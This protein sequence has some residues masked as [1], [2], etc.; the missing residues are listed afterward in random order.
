MF[1]L[2]GS[3]I[4]LA[5]YLFK[6]FS[7]MAAFF[8]A[9]GQW[10]R[11]TSFRARRL[12]VTFG[13]L[14]VVQFLLLFM[15]AVTTPE[16]LLN[17]PFERALTVASLGFLLWGFTP[18]LRER[19]SMGLMF[20]I[21]NTVLAFIAYGV[22]MVVWNGSDFNQT[23]WEIFF[24]VWQSLLLL[25]GIIDCSNRYNDERLFVLISF[26]IMLLGYAAHLMLNTQPHIPVFVR[27]FEMIAYPLLT[28]AIYQ[29][30]MQSLV[31]RG[32]EL[33]DLSEISLDQIT[34]LISLSKA[35]R[36]ITA[37]LELSEVL[38][39]ATQSIATALNAD[40]CALALPDEETDLSQL[41]LVSI[42][43]PSRQGRGEAV[44]FPLNDQTA[45]KHAAKNK[46]SIQIDEYQDD[47]PLQLLFTLM[48]AQDA[49]PL[50]IQPLLKND[51]TIGVLLLGNSISKRV[52][53]NAEVE[54][55]HALAEQVTTA[56]S[57]AK[58]YS[59]VSGKSQ[60]LS[61]TLRN[62]ELEAG[63]RRAA[64]ET[65]LKK[66]REEV[67]L[68]AQRLYDYE[69]AQKEKEDALQKSQ[70]NVAKLE[71]MLDRAKTEVEKVGRK[72][73]QVSALSQNIENYKEQIT[74]LEMEQA[75]LQTEIKKL[76]QDTSEVDRL[77]DALEAAN[78][79][80]RKLARALKKTRTRT[81]TAPIPILSEQKNQYHDLDNLSCGVVIADAN[82]II[83]QINI[84]A[85]QLFGQSKDTLRGQKLTKLA[86]S[87]LWHETVQQLDVNRRNLISGQLNIGKHIVRLTVSPIIATDKNEIDGT[88]TILYDY[89]AEAETQQ[90]KD[91]FIASLSQDLRTPMTSITG[92]TDLLLGE[93]V[94]EL[95]RL[96]RKFLQ[97]IRANTNR[98]TNMLND[99][100]SITTIDA[101]QL[102]LHPTAIDLAEIIEDTVIAL[103]TQME[104][105]NI[106]FEQSISSDLPMAEADPDSVHQIVINLLGNAIKATPPHGMVA[107]QADVQSD[108]SNEHN[109]SEPPFLIIRIQDTGGGIPNE[110]LNRVFDRFY[111]AS[112]PL[113]QGLGETGIG[114]AVA[115]SLIEAN[116]GQ[117][118]PESEIGKGTIFSFI[119]PISEQSDDPWSSFLGT[120]PPLDLSSD[121]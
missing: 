66:S 22:V 24:L 32:Q 90:T 65:E 26:G 49:G 118:W 106:S 20:L 105:K 89:T 81:P 51:E 95:N 72:G 74:T 58:S 39:G 110:D 50:L 102:E 19:E 88:V 112:N 16:N 5:Y 8:I 97:R 98:M 42:Y 43:N 46:Q 9:W 111:R 76:K 114:L 25:L 15:S 69:V 101:G 93:S 14:I 54:L 84:V 91:E 33:Q 115:K 60:Q 109:S 18:F 31:A 36:H 4:T 67:S 85:T 87:D 12:T 53:T 30:A 13:G 48:G 86:D 64:M 28:V 23:S 120:L 61:W 79:R 63:K 38:D 121:V 119:L 100:I 1:E 35:T 21:G 78:Q 6:L 47:T 59:A 3:E 2:G 80:V 17:V 117:I 75:K 94:G 73:K 52:F 62:Q 44:S 7:V 82:H 113:I 99:L 108:G 40:Q 56:I 55:N 45:V 41:R 77:N 116:G 34:G 68:F 103:R 83:Q 70:E 57:H 27:V 29:G 107:I 37:S 71:R 10:Q 104:E 11:H 92:Y 96:Q